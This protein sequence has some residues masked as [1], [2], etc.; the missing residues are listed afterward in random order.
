MNFRN[1][2][3]LVVGLGK[4]GLAASRLL[5]REGA[6]VTATDRRLF[7]ALPDDAK[8]LVNQGVKI[9]AGFH[10]NETFL[11]SDLIVLSPGVPADMLQITE[12][13]SNGIRVIG[14][15]ELAYDFL[16][17]PLIAVTG[18][19]GKSTTT[20]LIGEIIKA[21]GDSVFVGGNLGTP[22]SEYVLSGGKYSCIVAELSSFQLET[23]E[24]F[25]PQISILL[26]IS[27]DH[28]DRYHSMKEYEDAK[29]RIFENQGNSDF[30]IIN[31]D[32]YWSRG[33]N[34]RTKGKVVTFSRKSK[35]ENGVYV[36]NGKV[37]SSIENHTGVICEVSGIAIKG[38][39]NLEN[40]MAAVAAALL[41]GCSPEIIAN[42]LK[43]FKGL[44][45]RLEFVRELNGVKYINDSKGTN[46]GA[47]MKS[48]EGFSEPVL[49][50]A[51]GR[52]KAGDFT[53]L[54]PLIKDKVKKLILIGEAR[55]KIKSAL[56]QAAETVYADS[57]EEAV[58]IARRSS[59]KGDVV[60]LS[61]ACASFDMFKNFE[62]RGRRF[63]E[64]VRKHS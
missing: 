11:S 63:K 34:S 12:A 45:H 56:G 13:K 6:I 37:V 9:D 47:V 60:L 10:S 27:P 2:K 54:R 22:L 31:S 40:S 52:D 30:S 7:D 64:I 17:A 28:L 57:L 33:F 25:K 39:H 21:K 5:M 58:D 32:E 53:P 26:N 44:E 51:G 8:E 4:S 42:T 20:T 36:D 46:V 38:V 55:E 3:T 15:A 29:F 1:K 23:I 16:N 35:V 19:N 43:E 49:L 24:K 41:W 59:E 48:I 14:E 50:I 61:P 62:D 18:S